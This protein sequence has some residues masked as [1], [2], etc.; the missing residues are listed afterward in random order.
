MKHLLQRSTEIYQDN[1][2][3]DLIR[4]AKRFVVNGSLRDELLN[5]L[6]ATEHVLRWYLRLGRSVYPSQ[7]TDADPFK[8]LWVDPDTI[9]YD[10]SNS[11]IPMRFG[12][13]Y[14]GDWDQNRMR[15]ANKSV[16]QTLK[17]HFKDDIPWCETE[18]Y[19]QKRKKLEE[20]R[21]IRGCTTVDDLPDYFSRYDNL[22]NELKSEGYKSQRTLSKESPSDTIRQNLDAPKPS[23]NEI[24]V[25]IGRDGD[26]LLGYRGVH[27][28]SIAKLADV[29]S[30]AVQVLVRHQEW[31][32]IRDEIVNTNKTNSSIEIQEYADHPDLRDI[33]RV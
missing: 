2:V 18:Y 5:L 1:G 24:G 16:Y 23:M 33:V 25:C 8:V 26:L 3:I 6:P 17:S 32:S 15:V 29:D 14:D 19:M 31:Q 13:V 4:A 7:Y 27:R 9:L 10:V 11:S 30:V 28:L 20:G 12:K 22:Y 21:S